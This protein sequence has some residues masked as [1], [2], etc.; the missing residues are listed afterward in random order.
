MDQI[1]SDAGRRAAGAKRITRILAAL[2]IAMAPAFSNAAPVTPPRIAAPAV[3]RATPALW[4]IRDADTTVYLFGTFHTLDNRTAWFGDTV[5]QAFDAS[6]ELV[7]ETVIPADPSRGAAEV[8]E[9]QPDGS[10][11]LK[12]FIAQTRE[13]VRHGNSL[14]MS[15][16]NGADAVLR[17]V[18][19]NSGKPVSGLEQFEEQ[20]K[21]LA[22]IPTAPPPASATAQPIRQPTG[23]APAATGIG[24]T[25]ND[26]L[27]AW[28]RGDTG[29][30][31]TMLAG[32]EAKSPAAYRI[33]IADRNARWGQ[34]I[35]DRLEKPGTVFVAVGSGHLA[36]KDSV[37]SWLENHGIA[38]TRIT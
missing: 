33:L 19:E 26:L 8:T 24:V 22:T 6:G 18:A 35:I 23:P 1:G 10:R 11:R 25:M 13:A 30:F 28:T 38:A 27:T 9:V 5:R 34:W 12:P 20:L 37:Q 36:G 4:V 31:T 2:A 17:R 29:A 15:V 3:L 7:L 32:F 16:E 14:G 21:T